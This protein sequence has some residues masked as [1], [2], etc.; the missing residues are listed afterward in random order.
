MGYRFPLVPITSSVHASG[1]IIVLTLSS[2]YTAD[3][4]RAAVRDVLA[5]PAFHEHPAV[6]VDRSGADPPSPA[7][8]DTLVEAVGTFANA[9][10]HARVAILVADRLAFGMARMGV[11]K[12]ELRRGGPP[13]A[14]FCEEAAAVAWLHSD[15]R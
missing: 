8:V 10:A 6:L 7:F 9:M 4:W 15:A 12:F 3:D 14:V 11:T 5:D 1:K 2:P 13:M